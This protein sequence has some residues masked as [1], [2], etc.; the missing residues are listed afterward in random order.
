MAYRWRMHDRG[1]G[2][3]VLLLHAFPFDARM[4]DAQV[5]AL[6]TSHRVISVDMPGFGGAPPWIDAP[7]LD[8]WALDLL[9]QLR[10]QGVTGATIAGCSLGGYLAFAIHRAAPDFIRGL[11]LVDS[12]AVPDTA[13]RRAARLAD[14]ARVAR[15]GPAF[16][17]NAARED[18][19]IELG[20]YPAALAS[21]TAML[22]DATGDGIV[23]ALVA[24]AG[25]PDAGPQLKPLEVPVT[26]IRGE[27][28]PIVGADE[29]RA[30]AA[31]IPGATF[32][33][34][35]GAAHIPTFARPS[36]VTDALFSLLARTK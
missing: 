24:M 13:E 35:E 15:E 33:E 11:A 19:A 28:D 10:I 31:E 14:A 25:R 2:P 12:R 29:A 3:A 21:A 5:E 16:F 30:M 34:I 27:R 20:A 17:I 22:D 9:A 23:G 7:S 32:T 18:L 4:W 1:S 36:S 6:S 26:V 8:A